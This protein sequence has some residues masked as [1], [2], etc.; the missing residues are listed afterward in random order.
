MFDVS[1]SKCDPS[2]FFSADCGKKVPVSLLMA[3]I[4]LIHIFL[5]YPNECHCCTREQYIQK[6]TK[7]EP[8]LNKGKQ[9]KGF[10]GSQNYETPEQEKHRN[11]IGLQVH[12]IE[13]QNR[14]KTAE[15][16]I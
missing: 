13:L 10:F 5:Q 11:L 2:K 4:L 8:K 16:V 9:I 1:V 7:N 14:A 6:L 3:G 12:N 15:I